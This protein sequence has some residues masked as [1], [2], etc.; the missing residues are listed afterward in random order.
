LPA[1]VPW[2][3]ATRPLISPEGRILATSSGNSIRLWDVVDRAHPVRFGL[4]HDRLVIKVA[5]S[6]DGHT[7]AAGSDD[8]TARLWDLTDR[9]HPASLGQ[10]LTGHH[11]PVNAVA[12]S[13]DGRTLATGSDDQTAVLWDV[14]DR[15]H[16]APLGQPLTGHV[17]PVRAIAFSPDGRTLATGS[18]D[19]TVLLWDLSELNA[20]L[21]HPAE[22]ACSLT[23]KG[24]D[25]D[26]WIRR[27][28]GLPY[29]D[30]CPS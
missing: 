9:A 13:P 18:D 11:D 26:E 29:Q 25:R 16:P 10:P 30:T 5:F 19:H 28:S 7:M 8:G 3:R 27:I 1:G 22:R 14:T 15:A 17:G 20:L 21:S 12:F 6:P 24:L 23:G 2:W 4:A